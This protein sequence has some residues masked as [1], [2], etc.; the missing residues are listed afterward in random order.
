MLSFSTLSVDKLMNVFEISLVSW[1]IVKIT[2]KSDI[3]HS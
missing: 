3:I 1:Y 2:Y